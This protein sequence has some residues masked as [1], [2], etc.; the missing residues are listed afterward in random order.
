MVQQRGVG[1]A[2]VGRVLMDVD[3]RLGRGGGRLR[4]RRRGL[5]ENDGTRRERGGAGEH[6]TA[7]DGHV[8]LQHRLPFSGRLSKPLC[9]CYAEPSRSL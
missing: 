3:D 1:P 9:L 4:G 8:L 2:E 5:T 6:L 7:R